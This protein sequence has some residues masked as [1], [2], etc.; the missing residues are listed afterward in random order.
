M[1]NLGNRLTVLPYNTLVFSLLTTFWQLS[2]AC[3]EGATRTTKDYKGQTHPTVAAHQNVQ[4]TRTVQFS[5]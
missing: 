1:N 4:N 5:D 3:D 2:S